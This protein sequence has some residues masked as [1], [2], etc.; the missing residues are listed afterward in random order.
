MVANAEFL[1]AKANRGDGTAQAGGEFGVAYF[2]EQRVGLGGPGQAVGESDGLAEPSATM[3]HGAD[4]NS[5]AFCDFVIRQGAEELLFRS[6]PRMKLGIK[7]G[8]AKF[9]APGFDALPLA[10]KSGSQLLIR[11]GAH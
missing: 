1:A 4:G 9:Y 11:H 5:Q 3:G 6:G 7:L 8:D 2:S 10:A